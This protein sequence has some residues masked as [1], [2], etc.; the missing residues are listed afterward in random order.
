M[1]IEK[2]SFRSF[3]I[4]DSGKSFETPLYVPAT[5]STKANRTV[6]EYIDLIENVGY[7]AFLVSAY[8]YCKLKQE[9]KKSFEK[10]LS[11]HNKRG[12]FFFLDNGNYEAYWY[13]DGKWTIDGLKTALETVCP[14]FCFS[15]DVF[16]EKGTNSE[17]YVKDTVT[18]IAKTAGSQKTGSTVALF[19]SKPELFPKVAGKIV[20]DI[21]PEIVAVPERELG[22]SI[23]ERAL[24]IKNIRSELNKKTSLIP[25]HIL[26]TGNPISILVYTL[27]GADTFDAL[28]W[29]STFI[30]PKTGQQLP[31]SQK[32]LVNC[33]C[34]ACR[35]KQ[36]PYDYQVMTHN[37]IFYQAFM[38]KIRKSLESGTEESLLKEYLTDK[39]VSEVKKIAGLK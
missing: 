19:H 13:K 37:L 12:A 38:E 36:I 32:D 7:P 27:C 31:F 21:N 20:N 10:L 28:D 33:N 4:E 5:S 11:K 29:S 1:I 18:A 3:K 25:M 9:D 39:N 26:G 16:W 34:E 30:D 15:F 22:S 17:I 23:F 24:T 8:D 35:L 14:D 6:F 2:K